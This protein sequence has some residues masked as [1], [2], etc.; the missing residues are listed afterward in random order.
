MLRL[1]FEALQAPDHSETWVRALRTPGYAAIRM[2]ASF[3]DT[4]RE[5]HEAARQ[6]FW[7]HDAFK[8]AFRTPSFQGYLTPAPGV[9]ELFELK[10]NRRDA[11]FRMPEPVHARWQAAYDALE[12][13]GLTVLRI[14]SRA[15]TGNDAL[16]DLLDDSTFRLIHF[17]RIHAGPL[18]LVQKALADHTDSGLLT[19]APLSSTPALEVREFDTLAWTP[20]EHELEERDVLVF[21]GETLS[22]ISNN[23]FPSALHRPVARE[24]K[25]GREARIST[26]FFLRARPQAVLDVNICRSELIGPVDPMVRERVT[27]EQLGDNI[28]GARDGL[29]WKRS[30]YFDSFAYSQK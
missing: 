7:Q 3:V 11:M 14:A 5:L 27:V 2:P 21:V 1:D 28:G 6:F 19:I 9:H 12:E 25:V 4:R 17:D 10:R 30:P 29:P 22:R 16:L 13:V 15:L 20:I 18:D 26:P 8:N 24:M 23:W